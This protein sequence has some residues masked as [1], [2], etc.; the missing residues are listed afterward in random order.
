MASLTAL[1]HFFAQLVK[2]IFSAMK[3]HRQLHR[4]SQVHQSKEVDIM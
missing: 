1:S 3:P 4:F 2:S